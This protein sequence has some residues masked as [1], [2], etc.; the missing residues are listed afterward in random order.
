MRSTEDP[1]L[2]GGIA[3]AKPPHLNPELDAAAGD[4]QIM[5]ASFDAT[6]DPRRSLAAAGAR[7]IQRDRM[8]ADQHAVALNP[9]RVDREP[10]QR[11]D[12][13]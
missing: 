3:A 2:A 8:G 10:D 13:V 1:A 4:G 6:M 7:R 9:R 11:H 5:Q 12:V